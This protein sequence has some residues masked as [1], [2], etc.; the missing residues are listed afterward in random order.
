VSDQP[1]PL[2]VRWLIRGLLAAYFQR[3]ERFRAERAPATGP[4]LFVANHP[5]SITDAF[6][7]GT[8]VGRAV[9]FVAAIMLF[10][11][12][13]IAWLLK[14]CGVI[15]VNR[16]QDDPAKMGSVTDTFAACFQVL[17]SGGAVAIFPEG[18]TYDDARLKEIKTGAARIA[19][20]IE[21]RHGGALRVRLVP[22]GLTYS[23]KERFRSVALVHVGE[24][25]RVMDRLEAYAADPQA[26]VRGLSADIEQR[27]RGLI[28]DLPTLDHERVVAAVTRLYLERLRAANLIVTEPL[29]HEAET[30]VLTQ[31]I[32]TALR[33]F[34]HAAPQRLAA[35]RVDLDRYERWLQ[36]LG[37]SDLEVRSTAA[38]QSLLARATRASVMILAT[39]VALFGWLHH[40]LPAWLV[41]QAVARFTPRVGRKAQTPMTVMLSGMLALVVCYTLYVAVMWTVFRGW[42]A[43]LYALALPMTGLL[44]HYYF[45]ALRRYR[46]NLRTL[47]FF[48]QRPISRRLLLSLRAQLVA[49]IDEFRADYARTLVPEL[50]DVLGGD[51]G[52][53]Q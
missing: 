22:I 53:S 25:I 15:P 6:V 11:S 10:R 13:P 23:A 42:S 48:F 24:P 33:H 36:R 17:E 2:I 26:C 46:G 40:L 7:I 52:A 28:L 27:L 8:S 41:G 45:R 14:R 34:E 44:A 18:I 50:N 3:I 35:F 20:E 38:R 47:G 43:A 31:A 16:K 4:V 37:L 9:H 29:S 39:P 32:G 5:G 30:L 49:T 21:A 12:R 19:L 51:A 1:Q